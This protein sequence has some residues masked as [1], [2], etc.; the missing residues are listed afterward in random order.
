[1]TVLLDSWAWIEYWRGSRNADRAGS[2]I[3]SSEEAVI[4]SINLAEIYVWILRQY[5]QKQAET[6]KTVVEKRCSVI[7]LDASIA[8][9]AAKIKHYR[10][11]ALAD[12]IVLATAINS[13]AKVITGDR[14]FEGSEEVIFIGD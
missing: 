9:E 13:N 8:I 4:S 11:M 5:G 6:K 7:N 14:D 1:M 10:K 3:E 12:S 2:Y